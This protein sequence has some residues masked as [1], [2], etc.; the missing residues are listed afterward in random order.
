MR[1]MP[2]RPV[3]EKIAVRP[4]QIALPIDGKAR[5]GGMYEMPSDAGLSRR[6]DGLLFLSQERRQAQ[7]NVRREMRD[8]P[9]SGRLENHHVRP[10]LA[11]PVPV[12]G[13]SYHAEV[14]SLP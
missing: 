3:M 4:Q 5:Q 13:T 1:G 8:V 2:H 11:L 6:T 10:R 14:R 12:T 7:R 9:W